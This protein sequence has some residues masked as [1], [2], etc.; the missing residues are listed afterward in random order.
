MKYLCP[1]L[2]S[3]PRLGALAVAL[4]LGVAGCSDER[5]GPTE[6]G[7]EPALSVITEEISIDGPGLVTRDVAEFAAA[8]REI[9]NRNEVLV[10]VKDEGTPALS[11]AAFEDPPPRTSVIVG[12]PSVT[13]AE[14]LRMSLRPP[15]PS[16]E[17]V[18]AVSARLETLGA[19]PY[20][21]P[22]GSVLPARLP[23][24][25]LEEVIEALLA[26]PRVDHIQPNRKWPVQGAGSVRTAPPTRP[27]A[28]ALPTLAP[29]PGTGR[30]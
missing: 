4:L 26:D 3:P 20:R 9:G 28:R 25:G 16:A 11:A 29:G 19:P 22:I 18:A 8:L 21:A 10:Q 13:P 15:A 27:A 14:T 6:R 23:D 30:P 5:P 24:E 1:Q 2:S 7:G 12:L 17:S